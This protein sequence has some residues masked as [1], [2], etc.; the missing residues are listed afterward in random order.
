MKTLLAI[1]MISIGAAAAV[2][3]PAQAASVTISGDD[4]GIYLREHRRDH[5]RG[6]RYGDRQYRNHRHHCRIEI[7][8]H[9]R[10]HHR[11]F[12]RVRVCG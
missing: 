7:I 8:E 1:A 3:V 12:E 5:Y 10:H 6:M 2:S 11:V 4:G 9:W